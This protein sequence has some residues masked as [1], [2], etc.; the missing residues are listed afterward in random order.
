MKDIFKEQLV[1][2]VKTPRDL[3]FKIGII[4]N[5]FMVTMII[6]TIAASAPNLSVFI[7]I[8]FVL[9]V[10][11][12]WHLIKR[13]N[14]E[15]EY[16]VTN[17]ELDIDIIYNKSRRKKVFVGSI[18]DFQALRPLGESEHEHNFQEVHAIKD[19]STGK[20]GLY[21]HEFVTSYQGKKMHIIFEPNEEIQAALKMHLKR[22]VF[23][24]REVQ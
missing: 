16:C 4:F 2:K 24:F 7:P 12:S 10:W 3:I 22:G 11:G 21:T 20:K 5:A 9:V 23:K 17:N 19:Y 8:L 14:Q 1:K 15:F 13:R 6:F 18:G